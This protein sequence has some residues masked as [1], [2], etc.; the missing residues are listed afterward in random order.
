MKNYKKIMSLLLVGAI[1]LSLAACGKK[2][3]V[4]DNTTN[5]VP[6]NSNVSQGNIGNENN[7]NNNNNSQGSYTPYDPNQSLVNVTLDEVVKTIKN[8]YGDGYLPNMT[9]D[10]DLFQDKTGITSDLYSEFFAEVPMISTN[11]DSLF[12]VHATNG[13]VDKVSELLNAYR[14]NLIND[15]FQ[16]PMNI[17]KIQAS[18]VLTKNDYVIFLMVGT[19]NDNLE[20]EEEMSRHF[21]AETDKGINA[22]NQLFTFGYTEITPPTTSADNSEDPSINNENSQNPNIDT[23]SSESGGRLDPWGNPIVVLPGNNP[24]DNSTDNPSVDMPTGEE[25]E[26][27]F[28]S[29]GN[30]RVDEFS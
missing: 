14:E 5:N 12:I 17:P 9:L 2:E 22:I 28:G 29:G 23:G 25:P 11:V 3:K 18:T 13:N 1:M 20:T 6:N 15:S 8:T 10:A 30:T 27:D 4:D 19:P 24:V 26:L 21:L 7:E 16:Y